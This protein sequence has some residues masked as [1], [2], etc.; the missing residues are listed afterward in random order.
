MICLRNYD[1]TTEPSRFVPK[2]DRIKAGKLTD[3]MPNPEAW[4]T[5]LSVPKFI[6][7]AF[8]VRDRKL[9]SAKNSRKSLKLRLSKASHSG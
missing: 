5:V 4:E 6:R 2:L 3:Q 8:V 7:F 1:I 9:F